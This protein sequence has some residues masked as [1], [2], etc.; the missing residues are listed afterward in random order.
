VHLGGQKFQTGNELKRGVL[1]WVHSH[2]KTF[3]A[4]GISNM[5]GYW[6]KCV[7]VKVEYL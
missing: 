7:S 5:T 1:N 4:V 3:Y 2:D 6:K